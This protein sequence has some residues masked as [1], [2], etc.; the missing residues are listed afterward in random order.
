[1]A[2][3]NKLIF[4]AN[5]QYYLDLHGI[6]RKDLCNVCDIN[7]TTMCEWIAGRKYP[8]IDKIERIA[9]YFGI[10]KSDLIEQHGQEQDSGVAHLLAVYHDLNADGQQK[11][12]GYADDLSG[13]D[14]YKKGNT[15]LQGIAE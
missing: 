13:N 1:M 5:L 12:V 4:S 9:A 15:I 14:K 3:N 8:R 7:Y 11:L 2:N 6:S 10:P